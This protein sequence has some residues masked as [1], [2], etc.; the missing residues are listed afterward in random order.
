LGADFRTDHAKKTSL[1]RLRVGVFAERGRRKRCSGSPC[2]ASAV[3]FGLLKLRMLVI[4]APPNCGGPP[5]LGFIFDPATFA[6]KQWTG[7][8]A[9][10]FQTVV[11]LINVDL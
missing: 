10:G 1:A 6:L 5:H 3:S 7:I 11:T 9:Q 4:G 2:R 8:D